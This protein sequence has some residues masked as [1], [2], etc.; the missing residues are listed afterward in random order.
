MRKIRER[1]EKEFSKENVHQLFLTVND[2]KID[3]DN[4]HVNLE[5]KGLNPYE[6][7]DKEELYRVNANLTFYAEDISNAVP[8]LLNLNETDIIK[9]LVNVSKLIS[10][11]NKNKTDFERFIEA[12]VF[13]E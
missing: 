6:L 9:K 12:K 3:L 2:S 10:E 8:E 4:F 13:G 7:L 5:K 11:D 1:V